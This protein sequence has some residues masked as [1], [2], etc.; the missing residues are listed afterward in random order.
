LRHWWWCAG[1][2]GDRVVVEAA[3]VTMAEYH[4]V[5]DLSFLFFCKKVFG[6]PKNTYGK[7]LS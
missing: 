4:G 5:W 6:E 1:G 2:S 7:R 3:T